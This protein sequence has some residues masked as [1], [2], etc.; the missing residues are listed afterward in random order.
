MKWTYG[1]K[2]KLLA[3][4]VLLAL[5]LLVL[6]S[7]Y[8][9]RV[10]TKNV[11]NSISTMYEDRL[12]ADDYILKMTRNVYEIRER[13][14]AGQ[15]GQAAPGV[16]ILISELKQTYGIYAKTK[17]TINEHALAIELS[18]L[19]SG[20]EKAF[21]KHRADTSGETEKL[22]V[23]LSKLSNIQLEE[24]KLIMNNV[25]SQYKSIKASSQF[26]FA[27]IIV[28]LIVLQVLVFS[29]KSLVQAFR[30]NDPRLN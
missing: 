29:S 5:C 16:E 19:I 28:I 26:A 27:I 14:H 18:Q 1:I 17:L 12:I 30:P 3:S 7:N 13:L 10:H 2:N 20:F 8:L 6:L 21:T 11:K 4:I 23:T 9:D 15:P 25:E 22:L 24:S